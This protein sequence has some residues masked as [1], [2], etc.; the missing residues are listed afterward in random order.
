MPNVER[1]RSRLERV[2]DQFRDVVDSCRKTGLCCPIATPQLRRQAAAPPVVRPATGPHHTT[3]HVSQRYRTG[4]Y[5]IDERAAE[6]LT[7][8]P[9]IA[10]LAVLAATEGTEQIVLVVPRGLRSGPL[11]RQLVLDQLPA[12]RLADTTDPRSSHSTHRWCDQRCRSRRPDRHD[13][14]HVQLP[15]SRH[16]R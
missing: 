8:H 13:A 3:T 16:A 9:D 15:T 7:A 4:T 6:A 12:R 11:L 2:E 5:M 14:L 1:P 10:D